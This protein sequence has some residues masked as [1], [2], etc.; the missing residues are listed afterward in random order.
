MA[1][2][3]FK[4]DTDLMDISSTITMCWACD[5]TVNTFRKEIQGEEPRRLC[6]DAFYS[7]FGQGYGNLSAAA[8]LH[9]FVEEDGSKPQERT[10]DLDKFEPRS[11][12]N[13]DLANVNFM[14]RKSNLTMTSRSQMSLASHESMQEIREAVAEKMQQS[15]DPCLGIFRFAIGV[16]HP[17]ATFKIVWDL[18]GMIFLLR[19]IY[20]IP[21]QLFDI[22]E[23]YV[24]Q[25][26]DNASL[27][28][29]TIDI[30]L[31]FFTGYYEKG[32]LELHHKRTATSHS[33]G[34][35]RRK[36]ACNYIKTWLLLDVAVVGIDWWFQTQ[37]SNGSAEGVARVTKSIR[38]SKMSKV[39][40]LLREQISSEAG[41]I[42][43]GILVVILRMFVLQ[44]IIAC[45]WYGIGEIAEES[46]GKRLTA[47]VPLGEAERTFNYQYSTCL[48][49]AFAQLGIGS[50]EIDPET[51]QERIFC[52]GVAFVGL[53]SFSTLV[54]TVTSL[55][56]NLQKAQDQD[57][58]QQLFRDLRH[59]LHHNDIPIEL[60]QRVTRF[61]QHAYRAQTS[62]SVDSEVAIFGLLSKSLRAE[63]QFTRYR[64]C[65]FS[66]ALCKKMLVAEESSNAE[67]VAQ[68]LAVKTL[69]TLQLAQNDFIFTRGTVARTCYCALE[70][71]LEYV[72]DRHN[73]SPVPVGM[74]IAEMALWTPWVYL[75][76]LVSKE[77]SRCSTLRNVYGWENHRTRGY[78]SQGVVAIDV[79]AFCQTV[80]EMHDIKE[81][82]IY[83]AQ[84]IIE[85]MNNDSWTT[86]EKIPGKRDSSQLGA[87]PSEVINPLSPLV[88]YWARIRAFA[89]SLV[90]RPVGETA[91]FWKIGL[92]S[93]RSFCKVWRK[94]RRTRKPEGVAWR[95]GDSL[96]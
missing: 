79:E 7:T 64:H 63:L 61:I 10:D 14:R 82:A 51:T 59:F 89:K 37:E 47:F 9:D 73:R 41:I 8:V 67:M 6:H 39:S 93:V 20:F 32:R 55:M 18:F 90:P 24:I 54:S 80:A 34:R 96:L 86:N 25:W 12:W 50:V 65:L 77:M 68:H 17:H 33:Q 43:F 62:R 36:I 91:V 69:T 49:W 52:I 81:Q 28:F 84:N 16:I 35:K 45:G 3:L 2:R 76:G 92:P 87:D 19:D 26:L 13:L 57:P 48:H 46:E 11:C 94:K 22:P 29:W 66:L 83:L 70:D 38:L 85:E 30:I 56:S 21:L 23:T 75:G 5:R 27:I 31:S 15:K 44:H 4:K 58:E 95:K 78:Q 42:Y 60:S 40:L 71:N 88:R 72:I 53:I 74:C 1:A